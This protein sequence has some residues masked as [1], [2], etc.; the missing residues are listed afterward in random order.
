M[1]DLS[2]L[3]IE[4]ST[5]QRFDVKAYAIAATDPGVSASLPWDIWK[6]TSGPWEFLVRT[7]HSIFASVTMTPL[8]ALLAQLA[9]QAT[10]FTREHGLARGDFGR[11]LASL[12]AKY[13]KRYEIDPAILSREA[14]RQLQEVAKSLVGRVDA[15]VSQSFFD[16][17][18]AGKEQILVTM[19]KRGVAAAQ[20]AVESGR[21]LQYSPPGVIKDFVMTHFDLFLDG[22]YWDQPFSTLDFGST[23]ATEVA[24]ANVTSYYSSLLADAVWLAEQGEDELEEASR[25]RLL[26]ASS[27]IQILGMGTPPR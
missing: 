2:Q 22:A 8:D 26:R 11:I 12:R 19:A 5:G 23:T 20:S 1:A 6:S 14:E 13:A 25:E 9:W 21:F 24:R 3:Y 18:G 10:D 7:D 17:L 27:S 16:G 4:D 15:P